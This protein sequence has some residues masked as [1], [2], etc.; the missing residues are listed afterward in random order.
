MHSEQINKRERSKGVGGNRGER[1][2]LLG[3]SAGISTISIPPPFISQ[4]HSVLY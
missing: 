1:K 3:I 4:G 2:A